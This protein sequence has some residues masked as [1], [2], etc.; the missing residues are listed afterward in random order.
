M[1]NLPLIVRSPA[2]SDMNDGSP[3]VQ[4]VLSLY[5]GQLGALP[6]TKRGTIT[7]GFSDICAFR[8][9]GSTSRTGRPLITATFE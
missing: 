1:G 7:D 5:D 4:W 6:G 2:G 9:D 3:P 8:A